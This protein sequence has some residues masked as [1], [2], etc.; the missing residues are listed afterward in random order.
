M[1]WTSIYKVLGM[2][3]LQ[4]CLLAPLAA[5][6]ETFYGWMD[7]L[8]P[9][10]LTLQDQG[11]E[12]VGELKYAEDGMI[13]VVG[14][15]Y[16]GKIVLEEKGLNDDTMGQLELEMRPNALAGYWTLG[17]LSQ[18]ILLLPEKKKFKPFLIK[19]ASASKEAW[20]LILQSTNQGSF[21]GA[22]FS[23]KE[24]LYYSIKGQEY[25]ES[26]LFFTLYDDQDQAVGKAQ[27]EG[28][29]SNSM[30]LQ[31]GDGPTKIVNFIPKPLTDSKIDYISN[32]IAQIH[33]SYPKLNNFYFD[34]WIIGQMEPLWERAK[35]YEEKVSAGKFHKNLRAKLQARGN[36]SISY[37]D[38]DFVG[39]E[40]RYWDSWSTKTVAQSFVFDLKR[41]VLVAANDIL[42]NPE[43]FQQFIKQK[44]IANYSNEEALLQEWLSSAKF[45]EWSIRP[46]GFWWGTN[47]HPLFGKVGVAI[48]R[49][50]MIPFLKSSHPF[51]K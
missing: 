8:F 27:M 6:P 24:N 10:E 31:M 44:I 1:Q 4:A 29:F 43:A 30:A 2:L 45:D 14:K 42:N 7:G 3:I 33:F 22:F 46:N 25:S 16:K 19:W 49:E 32:R 48:S 50:E 40:I 26:G 21:Q 5:Q 38:A 51:S 39:G 35:G 23:Q 28:R 37:L 20:E 34:R 11:S 15:K 18:S 41:G 13:A 9:I 47:F 36:C 12:K 17:Q